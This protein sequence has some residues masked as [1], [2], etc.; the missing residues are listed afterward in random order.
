VMSD[1]KRLP[2]AHG[3]RGAHEARPRLTPARKPLAHSLATMAPSSV[4]QRI[5]V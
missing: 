3:V 5:G 2:L 4:V 1:R